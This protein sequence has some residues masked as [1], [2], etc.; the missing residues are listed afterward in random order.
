M[1][2]YGMVGK[3]T[4]KQIKTVRQE[5]L[6]ETQAEFAARFYVDQATVSRWEKKGPPKTGPVVIALRQLLDEVEAGA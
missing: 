6:D 4:P 5:K 2:S 3:I 1:H